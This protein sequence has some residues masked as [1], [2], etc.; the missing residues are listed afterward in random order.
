MYLLRVFSNAVVIPQK[1]QTGESPIMKMN[2][3]RDLHKSRKRSPV[4]KQFDDN[5]GELFSIKTNHDVQKNA[6]HLPLI[7]NSSVQRQLGN[8]P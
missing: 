1:K 2:R 8:L 5:F 3:R 4:A 6:I 7:Y